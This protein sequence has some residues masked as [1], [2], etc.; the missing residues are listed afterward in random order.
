VKV[1]STRN[2]V[3]ANI[4]ISSNDKQMIEES[5]LPASAAKVSP[6]TPKQVNR[7]HDAISSDNPISSPGIK[8]EKHKAKHA[9][10]EKAIS[11]LL[12]FEKNPAAQALVQ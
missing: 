11:N 5:K 3:G 7:D 8:S 1:F 4:P 9:S 12:S 2:S 10:A 6:F